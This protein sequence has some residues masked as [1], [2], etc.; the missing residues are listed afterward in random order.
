M[1]AGASAAGWTANVCPYLFLKYRASFA[2]KPA[3]AGATGDVSSPTVE[4]VSKFTSYIEGITAS[5]SV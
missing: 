5:R 3:S 2:R 4:T 1:V